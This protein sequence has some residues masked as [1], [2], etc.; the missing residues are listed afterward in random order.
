MSAATREKQRACGRRPI[1]MSQRS[2]EHTRSSALTDL[3]SAKI[4]VAC[5]ILLLQSTGSENLAHKLRAVRECEP[6]ENMKLFRRTHF[7][8]NHPTRKPLHKSEG[9]AAI[10]V[11]ANEFRLRAQKTARLLEAV[12]VGPADREAAA[13]SAER[14]DAMTHLKVELIFTQPGQ[15]P[16]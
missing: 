13:E 10:C 9:R 15:E 5:V 14:A 16:R 3:R 11:P 7:G 2:H 4:W 6:S 1:W 8:P 12:H